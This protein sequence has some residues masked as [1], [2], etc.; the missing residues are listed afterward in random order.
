MLFG[1]LFLMLRVTP[2]LALALSTAHVIKKISRHPTI[3]RALNL[4]RPSL[5]ML[6]GTIYKPRAALGKMWDYHFLEITFTTQNAIL[7]LCRGY[8]GPR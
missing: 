8:V 3:F 2:T 5:H 1:A 4:H 6:K 7:A